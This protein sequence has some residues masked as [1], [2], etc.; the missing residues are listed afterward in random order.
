MIGRCGCP[1]ADDS[2]RMSADFASTS[3]R[4]WKAYALSQKI[5]KSGAAVG[6]EASRLATSW[7]TTD[8]A[9]LA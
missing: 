2:D 4:W 3:V 7:V 8:P 9:G 1:A 6:I 5:R